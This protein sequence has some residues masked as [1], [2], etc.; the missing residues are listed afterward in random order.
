MWFLPLSSLIWWHTFIDLHSLMFVSIFL[1]YFMDSW[2]DLSPLLERLFFPRLVERIKLWVHK[3]IELGV[4][5]L[6]CYFNFIIGYR[7]TNIVNLVLITFL[8]GFIHVWIHKYFR[9]FCLLEY[10]VLRH[11]LMISGFHCYLL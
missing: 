3:D 11:D 2:R 8:A 6:N 7:C 10:E 1:F 5:F 4:C 9:L